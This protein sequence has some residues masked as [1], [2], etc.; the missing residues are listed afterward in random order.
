MT[1]LTGATGPTDD[2][3]LGLQVGQAQQLSDGTMMMR[4]QAPPADVDA[5]RRR[6]L[7][8]HGAGIV[9]LAR[10]RAADLRRPDLSTGYAD[11]VARRAAVELSTATEIVVEHAERVADQLEPLIGQLLHGPLIDA[12]GALSGRARR[13]DIDQQVT[14]GKLDERDQLVADMRDALTLCDV[15][16]WH[17]QAHV[18]RAI[19]NTSWERHRGDELEKSLRRTKNGGRKVDLAVTRAAKAHRDTQEQARRARQRAAAPM[20]GLGPRASG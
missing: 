3:T 5:E 12:I 10:D 19:D 2:A 17:L 14:A 8:E 18:D 11:D 7:Q 15:A 13:T 9:D 4:L 1:G 20:P 16:L 6:I